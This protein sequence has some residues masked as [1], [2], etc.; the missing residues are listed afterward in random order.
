MLFGFNS[1]SLLNKWID[2]PAALSY[3]IRKGNEVK[4]N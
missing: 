4:R 1:L 3:D 2:L